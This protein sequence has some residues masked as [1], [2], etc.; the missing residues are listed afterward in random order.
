MKALMALL[1]LMSLQGCTNIVYRGEIDA[2][3]S[4]GRESKALLYWTETEKLF[5]PDKAGPAVLMTECSTHRLS[6]VE[7]EPGIVFFGTPGQDEL[8]DGSAEMTPKTVCGSIKNAA[9]FEAIKP[10]PL[11]VQIRCKASADDEGFVIN[12]DYLDARDEPYRFEIKA[13]RRWSLFGRIP[14]APAPPP[15]RN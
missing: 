9:K 10:G 5:G 11:E 13:S 1:I 6:F 15:C 2:L 3:N 4:A 12:S 7:A 8:A 14:E